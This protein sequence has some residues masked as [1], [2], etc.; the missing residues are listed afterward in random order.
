ME[1]SLCSQKSSILFS[2]KFSKL[3][4]FLIIVVQSLSRVRLV[5]MDCSMPDFPVLH[6][7]LWHAQIHVHWVDDAIQ[8]SCPLLSPSPAFNLF[9]DQGLSQWVS[10]LLQVAKYWSFS[11]RISPS[12]EYSR[13][14]SF[15]MDWLDLA[16]QGT[17]KS[18]L[19]H[20]ISK[21][22]ILLCSTFFMVQLS[23]WANSHIHTWLLE[24]P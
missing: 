11:F 24:K 10:S 19:Q 18:L 2:W 23:L 16:V 8:P 22:S 9:Q 3:R 20:H 1:K 21:T 17:L 15:R 14:I 12:D 4:E 5:A 6:H 13:L 7:L